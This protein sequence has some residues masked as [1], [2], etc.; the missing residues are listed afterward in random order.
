MGQIA[1]QTYKPVQPSQVSKNGIEPS[2]MD[3]IEIICKK[4]ATYAISSLQNVGRNI[5]RS[6][7]AGYF[8]FFIRLLMPAEV[9]SIG[10]ICKKLDLDMTGLL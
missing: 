8:Y 5:G 2:E 1:C 6:G 9:V 10:G 4:F 3:R 7:R